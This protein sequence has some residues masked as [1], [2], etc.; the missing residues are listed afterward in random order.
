[1]SLNRVI[2]IGNLTR[3]P[4]LKYTPSGVPLAQMG[5][6][7]NR[8]TKNDQG[9]YDVDFFNIVAWRRTAEFASNY[10]H[11]GNRVAIEGRLQTRSWIDQTTGQNRTAYEIV[12][13]NLQSLTGRAEAEGSAPDMH[14]GDSAAAASRVGP[15]A[16]NAAPPQRAAVPVPTD[17]HDMDESDPFADE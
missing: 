14:D 17:D 16:R 13:D 11:K 2:L 3:E 8:I 10:L 1:M 6:A 9:A 4:E 15:P 12:A 5:I 7:V